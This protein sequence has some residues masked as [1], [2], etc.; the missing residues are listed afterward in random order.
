MGEV[1]RS[2]WSGRKSDYWLSFRWWIMIDYGRVMI[3]HGGAM[4]DHDSANYEQ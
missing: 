1:Y 4:I 2:K 3:D